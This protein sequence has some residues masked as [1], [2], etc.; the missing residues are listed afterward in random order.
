MN[1]NGDIRPAKNRTSN[2]DHWN[3]YRHAQDKH[4]A[5]VAAMYVTIS[6]VVNRSEY[7]QEDGQFPNSSWIGSRILATWPHQNEWNNACSGDLNAS[8]AL[9]GQ[10]MWTVMFDHPSTWCTTVTPNASVDREERV[11]WRPFKIQ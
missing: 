5:I 3:I 1:S 6:D 8:N 4:T 9:F 11:Y 7:L 10:I 2:A